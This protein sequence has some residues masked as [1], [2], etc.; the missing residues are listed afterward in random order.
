[1]TA[2]HPQAQIGHIHLTVAD[3]DRAEKF[4]T[5]ILGFE[6]TSRFSQHAVFLS[7][8][9]YHHHIALNTWAGPNAKPPSSG[10]TGLYHFAILLPSRLE[11]AKVVKR[12][13]DCQVQIDGASDHH[14]SQ[15]V[16]LRDPDG[17]GIELYVDRD[18]SEWIY[19][20]GELV[21]TVDPLDLSELLAELS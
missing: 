16:Y 7:A 4:Y 1:M 5:E 3:L 14:V 10:S 19:Q 20:D 13:I 11:L 2:I 21:M 15:A 6:V 9:G 18:P 12:V 17:N 8:G